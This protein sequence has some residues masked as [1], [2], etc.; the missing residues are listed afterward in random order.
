MFSN[1]YKIF[2][3]I[4]ISFIVIIIIIS[5]GMP[6]FLSTSANSNKL[7]V[8]KVGNEVIT[9]ND[10]WRATNNYMK[11]MNST[12]IP[13]SFKEQIADQM[14]DQL[15]DRKLYLIL[16]KQVGLIPIGE[17]INKV[18]VTFLK[19]NFSTYF[20]DLTSDFD[21]FKKKIL[22]P[23]YLSLSDL[24]KSVIDDYAIQN[25][26]SLMDTI[27][28]GSNL[29]TAE[30]YRIQQTKISYQIAHLANDKIEQKLKN[31]IIITD[32]EIN[33]IFKEKYLKKN[34]KEVLNDIKKE[35]IKAELIQTKLIKQ[36]TNLYNI[37][38]KEILTTPFANLVSKYQ[39]KT[40]LLNNVT[41]DK[42]LD[43]VK[44]KDA[45]SFKSIQKNDK[46]IQLLSM[47]NNSNNIIE[48][49]KDFFIVNI[50]SKELTNLPPTS[51]IIKNKNELKLALEKANN[52]TPDLQKDT[53]FL[54][55]A[56]LE[57]EKKKISI[58]HFKNN[59]G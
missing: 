55:K 26:Y 39:M 46:F 2:S 10:V 36:K 21:G 11:Q 19:D 57:I 54:K 24:Q 27:K 12:T 50:I 38:A 22:D 45:P 8:A 13:E 41:L 18:F 40:Y 42:E 29:E 14:T 6:D 56:M 33:N 49:N 31:E 32:D 53:E 44:E 51:T 1:V 52:I 3:Y 20:S 7:F 28:L 5:F 48:D 9:R 23:N 35:S 25:I 58:K 59:N 16:S 34:K 30:Q 4:F 47:P 37:I 15:I 43:S 17:A